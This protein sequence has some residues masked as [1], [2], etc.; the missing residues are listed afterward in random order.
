MRSRA[1]TWDPP[2]VFEHEWK[3]EP[4]SELPA[5]ENAVIR[6]ELRRDG[7]GTMLHL[8]HRNLNRETELGFASGD[9]RLPRQVRIPALWAA[10]AGLAG[11]LRDGCLTTSALLAHEVKVTARERA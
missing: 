8:E 9:A 11:A 1:L 6:W 10:P 7:E 5:G 2:A 4:R 3:V